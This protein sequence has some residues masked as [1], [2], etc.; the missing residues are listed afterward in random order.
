MF[1]LLG[2][3]NPFEVCFKIYAELFEEVDAFAADGFAVDMAG[4]KAEGT[5]A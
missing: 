1:L 4:R 2:I 5:T 3:C